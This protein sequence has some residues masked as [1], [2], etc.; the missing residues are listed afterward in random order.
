MLLRNV[1]LNNF[2]LYFSFPRT[3]DR[4]AFSSHTQKKFHK[5]ILVFQHRSIYEINIVVCITHYR[6]NI[7]KEGAPTLLL[8]SPEKPNLTQFVLLRYH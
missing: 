3:Y 6:T 2:S 8:H 5:L 4:S 1:I 7:G